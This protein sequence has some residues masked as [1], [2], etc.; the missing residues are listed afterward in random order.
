M[1]CLDT[2]VLIPI[3]RKEKKVL[4]R[5]RIEAENGASISTTKINLCELYI[6]AYASNNPHKELEKV[7]SIIS[8][9][10]VLDLTEG[11]SRKYGQLANSG[12]LKK[13]PIGD[14]DLMIACIALEFREPLAT[15][16]AT[17]F[18]RVP[19]LQIETW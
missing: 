8:A 1:V 10:R 9:L 5:L 15:R 19:G 18:E 7:Q 6:G 14:F 12:I 17:H 3:I 2:S 4:E 16:N 11:A 13:N